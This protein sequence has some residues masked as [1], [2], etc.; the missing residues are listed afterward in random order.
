[1]YSASTPPMLSPSRHLAAT[2]LGECDEQPAE[3]ERLDDAYGPLLSR[4]VDP[5]SRYSVVRVSDVELA[6]TDYALHVAALS[7][8]W[9]AGLVPSGAAS[10]SGRDLPDEAPGLRGVD[11]DF[12]FV[13]PQLVSRRS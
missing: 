8:A 5:G 10:T 2:R 7:D 3:R 6:Y 1:M 9:D 13:S 11:C 4:Q 12:R